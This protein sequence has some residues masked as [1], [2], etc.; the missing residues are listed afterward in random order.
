MSEVLAGSNGKAPKLTY[1]WKRALAHGA[2]RHRG[3]H[4]TRHHAKQHR[5]RRTKH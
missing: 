3:K 5:K 1:T 4:H 2:N